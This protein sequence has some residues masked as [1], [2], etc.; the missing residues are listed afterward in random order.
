MNWRMRSY[1]ISIY[2]GEP[3]LHDWGRLPVQLDD[4]S[5]LYPGRW[6][7]FIES[8]KFHGNFAGAYNLDEPPQLSSARY[9]S[10][11]CPS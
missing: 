4:P 1:V 8:P 10:G 6:Y 9:G 2:L 3:R 11:W 5:S 7:S